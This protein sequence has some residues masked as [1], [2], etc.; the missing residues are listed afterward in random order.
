MTKA[1]PTESRG[2]TASQVVAHNLT[3]ARELRGLTQ[4]EVAERLTR[5]T[6]SNWSQAT[7]AQAE[8]SIAGNRVRQ[9][10]ANELVALA[11]AFDLPLLYFF[12]PPDD[13]AGRLVTDDA[14][15]GHPWEYLVLLLLGHQGNFD[16]IADRTA[17]WSKVLRRGI[18]IPG[19]DELP[20]DDPASALIA[21]ALRHREP[22]LPEDVL[23]SVFHGLAS[24]RVRGAKQP[25]EDLT[26]FIE[27]LRGLA[28]ALTAFNNYPPGT[29]V[30]D[31][32]VDAV[33]TQRRAREQRR[34]AALASPAEDEEDIDE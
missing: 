3:R 32:V 2:W 23:A 4:V 11:R 1:K 14:E 30:D 6:G 26:T 21:G 29:F 5:F 13:A 17:N 24:R 31:E 20:T 27:N 34:T 9:F 16:V 8:G 7:V 28:D 12:L 25:G 19:G 18:D 22:L 10:T 33:A 15:R